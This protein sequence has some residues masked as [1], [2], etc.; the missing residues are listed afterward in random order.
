MLKAQN[1]SMNQMVLLMLAVFLG[2]AVRCLN[3]FASDAPPVAPTILDA[4]QYFGAL[5]SAHGVA[6]F[7]ET[8]SKNGDILGYE[9]FPVHGYSGG[10][11]HSGFTLNNSVKIDI[12]WSIV[13]KFQLSDGS[14][15]VL[16]GAEVEFMFVHMISVEG[17]IVIEPSNPIPRLI[18]G[19]NDELSRNRLLKAIDLVSTACRSKSKFD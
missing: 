8:R 1:S 18:F 10:T 17:G 16:H 4:H 6:A 9:I 19:I 13:N 7:Y 12:D 5:V 3:A 15:S 14:L 11:C 2:G